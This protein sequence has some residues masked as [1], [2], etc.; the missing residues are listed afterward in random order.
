MNFRK[1][2]S[3]F[4]VA[5]LCVIPLASQ[6]VTMEEL[7]TQIS[8]LLKEV[9]RLSTLLVQNGGSTNSTFC[10]FKRDLYEGVEGKDVK[11]LQQYLN[12]VGFKVAQSGPGSPGFETEYFGPGTKIA[13]RY[14]QNNYLNSQSTGYWGPFSRDRYIKLISTS[15]LPQT[16]TSTAVLTDT[17]YVI[18]DTVGL[19]ASTGMI[20]SVYSVSFVAAEDVGEG[21]LETIE[22]CEVPTTKVVDA[23][24]LINGKL[25]KL[26]RVALPQKIN[27]GWYK[28][29]VSYY[30]ADYD[31]EWRPMYKID[32]GLLVPTYASFRIEKDGVCQIQYDGKFYGAKPDGTLYDYGESQPTNDFL[33]DATQKKSVAPHCSIWG[34]G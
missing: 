29:K 30:E 25:I 2:F 18:L 19:P 27:G 31:M 24:I 26:G 23:G 10:V 4:M 13:A 22:T 11:C 32:W 12:T 28:T 9:E 33:Y 16:T 3:Y 8:A 20:S 34:C 21:R 17:N 14:W 6:A 15:K 1:I 5:A 7:Q